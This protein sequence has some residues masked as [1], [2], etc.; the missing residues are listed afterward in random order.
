[1]Q[2]HCE[3]RITLGAPLHCRPRQGDPPRWLNNAA[4]QL[5]WEALTRVKLGA[6]TRQQGQFFDG[7]TRYPVERLPAYYFDLLFAVRGV[8]IR[9]LNPDDPLE[10]VLLTDLGR[11]RLA[12]LNNP[13]REEIQP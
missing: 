10:T 2:T 5:E 6:V 8:V 3:P 4:E 11:R 1:M 7:A 12:E 9:R 13:A